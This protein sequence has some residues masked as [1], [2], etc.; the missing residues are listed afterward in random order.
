MP[1][2]PIAVFFI[3]SSLPIRINFHSFADLEKPAL[4]SK[5]KTG[6]CRFR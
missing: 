2:C 5:E 1:V 6:A 4:L 3:L